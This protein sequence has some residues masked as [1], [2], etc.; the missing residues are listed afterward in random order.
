LFEVFDLQYESGSSTIDFYNQYRNLVVANLK[1]RG[2]IILWQNNKILNADEE[3]SPTFEEMIL[4]N[5]LFQIDFQLLK[6]VTDNY[7]HLIGRM[8]SL[9]D[10]KIDI[11]EKVPAFLTKTE[12]NLP[13]KY[14][15]DLDE[16]AR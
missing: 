14:S 15:S 10:Y 16:P 1:K 9:M 12:D 7:Q 3:L 8:K 11:L 2:D 6:H 13:D 4:A 5:V